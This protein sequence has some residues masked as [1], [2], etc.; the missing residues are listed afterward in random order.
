MAD[1]TT[2][3][4]NSKAGNENVVPLKS[5]LHVRGSSME[6]SH[7]FV[8]LPAPFTE[9]KDRGKQALQPLLQALFDNLDDALFELADKAEHNLE[10]NMYFESMREVRIKRRSMELGFGQQIDSALIALISDDEVDGEVGSELRGLPEDSLTLVG[11]DDLEELVATDNMVRRAETQFTDQLHQLTVRFDTLV[12]NAVVTD[13]NNPFGPTVIC[14]SFARV[15]KKLDL[16]I[17][18]RLVL[19]K[20]FDRYVMDGLDTVYKA[21]NDVLINGGIL[22]GLDR[23]TKSSKDSGVSNGS[24]ANHSDQADV[25]SR[26]QQLMQSM[27]TPQSA[28][29]ANG[30][31]AF[32]QAPQIPRDSLFQLLQGV[33]H[34]LAP[35]FDQQLQAAFNGTGP[36]H[37]NIQQSL[38]QLL[39]DQLPS[40]PMSLGQGDGDTINLVAMLFQFILEDRNLAAPMKALI[41]RLQIPMVKVAMLDKSFFSKGGHPARKLLNEVASASLGWTVTGNVDRDP[42]YTKVSAIVNKIHNEFENDITLFQDVLADFVAFQEMDKR[43]IGLVEQRTINAEDGKAK[44]ELARSTVQDTLNERVEG[45]SLPKVVI[46]LLEQAW[47][48]VLFLT[49]LKEGTDN[50]NW[51]QAVQV[52]DDLVWSVQ[53]MESADS[54]HKLLALVPRL[55]N[56]L[57]AGLTKIGYNPYD[58][59]KLFSDLEKIHLNQLKDLNTVKLDVSE[60]EVKVRQEQTHRSIQKQTEVIGKTLDQV[61][62]ERSG[63][64]ASLEQL[65]AELDEQLAELDALGDLVANIGSEETVK[66][67]SQSAPPNEHAA[68]DALARET[69]AALNIKGANN[70]S[71]AVEVPEISEDDPSLEKADGLAMGSWIELHQDD[72]KKFRCRLAAVIRATGKYIF[73]NRTGMKV[74]E[75]NR[76]TLAQ[77]IKLGQVTLLDDGQL[78]D[79]ALE[80]V[81]GNLRDMKSSA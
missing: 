12:G 9:A 20:L 3:I 38:S 42:L 18:A 57:R 25:F 26:L 67:T 30:L 50:E 76:L 4:S 40:K 6:D 16:D 22:P 48:N 70:S 58:M 79:R 71:V 43:R 73:V 15:C 47:S 29:A 80:S 45:L 41:S 19:F 63:D 59:N 23:R 62:E 65:D 13:A 14:G 75:Y 77:A 17:K 52:V 35:T 10:Q 32:G 55:L 39:S 5:H 68:D 27:P 61:L 72:D 7:L 37:L 66:S 51:V 44:T 11:D 54:R 24:A 8:R 1:N 74:A 69:V 60:K 81:I 64:E 21:C 2:S 56:T 28:A 33:Q 34:S 36:Q 31:V 78:F 46:T 49:C 53:P